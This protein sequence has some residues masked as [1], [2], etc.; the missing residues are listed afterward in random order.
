[1]GVPVHPNHKSDLPHNH[2][3]AKQRV[4]IFI[5]MDGQI[6]LYWA[7]VYTFSTFQMMLQFQHT[8]PPGIVQYHT[9]YQAHMCI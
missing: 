4:I 1:M 2:L 3:K 7:I 9:K 8:R 5:E 6:L